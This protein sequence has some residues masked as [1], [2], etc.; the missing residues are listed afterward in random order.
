MWQQWRS[1][2]PIMTLGIIGACLIG[3]GLQ[4]LFI[5]KPPVVEI[6]KAN[7]SPSPLP[8][9][10]SNIVVD[11]SGAVENPGV[12]TLSPGSRVSD[13]LV[14][15]GG[16]AVVADKNYLARN[17]N[18]ASVVTDGSKIYIL[19]KG[20]VPTVV[21][22]NT[23]TTSNGNTTS[24]VSINSASESELDRLWGIGPTR[25]QDIITNR[26]YTTIDE[27]KSKAK[28]PDSVFSKIK[29]EISL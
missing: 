10:I 3:Y 15:A 25:A 20:E 27:L 1:Y 5:P 17:V 29:I 7:T 2:L 24:L 11:V 13:A 23:T 12:Y 18:L 26:P 8:T 6:I 16:L 9:A 28:I 19:K 4:E 14:A 22:T 21:T